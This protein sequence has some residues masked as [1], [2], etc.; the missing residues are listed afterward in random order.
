MALL[1]RAA[2]AMWWDMAP[3]MRSEFQQ[4]HSQEH[5]PERLALPGFLRAT[6]WASA[7]GGEGFF[8]M[9]E[10]ADLGALESPEYLARLNA[11][12]PWSTQL[13]PHH[14]NMVRCMSTVVESHG[15]GVARHALTIRSKEGRAEGDADLQRW[16]EAAGRWCDQPGVAGVHLLHTQKLTLDVTAEQR[17]RGLADRTVDAILVA[18]AWESEAL[19]EMQASLQSAWPEASFA[20]Y[21]LAMSR[22]ASEVGQPGQR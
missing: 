7:D 8:V 17:I 11:P 14:R 6:R 10:V 5:F 13:M 2:L 1:G 15:A 9:Y 12:T 21:E 4:W 19:T 3:A 18:C 20:R 16:R 22:H